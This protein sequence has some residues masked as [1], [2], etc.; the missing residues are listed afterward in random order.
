MRKTIWQK[1]SAGWLAGVLLLLVLAGCQ[2]GAGAPTAV[3]QPAPTMTQAADTAEATAVDL[4]ITPAQTEGP[5]YP[6]TEPP[7]RDSDLTTVPGSDQTA[8][9]QIL[10]LNGRV[11]YQNGAPAAGAVVEIW[12]TDDQG[13]YMH[14]G[15]AGTANRDPNFQFF[16][17]AVTG[18]DGGYAFKTIVP[19]LYEPRPRHIHFKVKVGG[20]TV[21]TSQFYFAGFDG[22]SGGEFPEPL[23]LTAVPGT[24]ESGSA[25]LTAQKDIVLSG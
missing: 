1:L 12:Q 4:T 14:P 18:A 24:D 21:L 15:D 5:Y 9:G 25:I 16:G 6:V 3:N 11:L 17:E 8:A 22:L 19:G 13:I 20:Q 10:W 7:D 2:G 23:V